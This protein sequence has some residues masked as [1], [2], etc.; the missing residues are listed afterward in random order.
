[1]QKIYTVLSIFVVAVLFSSCMSTNKMSN[2]A[3]VKNPGSIAHHALEADITIDDSQKLKGTSKST[4]FLMFRI[5]GDSEYAD[6]INYNAIGVTDGGAFVGKLIS[7][8]NPLNLINKLFTGDAASKVKA[9]AAYD[10]L[11]N[12]DADFLAHPTYTY[13]KKNW[14]FIQQFEASVEGYPG[15]YSNFRS[16]DPNQR[17][18]DYN[19]DNKVNEKIVKKLGIG[20][21]H[22]HEH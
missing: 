17:Y 4:Y 9:S 14:I 11:S 20:A 19:L 10:A 1:M 7:L 8:L 12:S 21:N 3:V 22:N 2:S 6:G 5:E 18:L 16:Y 13:T 15:K